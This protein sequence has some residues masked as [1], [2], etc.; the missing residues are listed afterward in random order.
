ML[1]CVTSAVSSCH[2]SLVCDAAVSLLRLPVRNVCYDAG[3]LGLG[4]GPEAH[5]VGGRRGQEM[6]VRWASRPRR[7]RGDKRAHTACVH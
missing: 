7:G 5:V 6:F 1:L 3:L 4:R 2:S